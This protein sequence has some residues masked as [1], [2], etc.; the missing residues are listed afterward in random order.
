VWRDLTIVQPLEQPYRAISG[1]GC[2]PVG[3]KIEV[4]RDAVHHGLGNG[5]LVYA[6]G[7]RALGVEDYPDLVVDQIVRIVGEERIHALLCDPRRLRI[8]QRNLL[9]RFACSATAAR[10]ATMST[11]ALP[12]TVAGIEGRKVFS[13]GT[14]CL[15]SLR[16]GNRLVARSPLGLVHIRLDQ[17]RIDR[18][19]LAANKPGSNAY[20]HHALEYSPQSVTLTKALVTRAAEYRMIGNLVLDAELAKPPV[21]QI[22]LNLRAEPPL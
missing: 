17:A 18:K 4:A 20:R 3:P 6:I 22:D 11:I 12:I 21:R 15:L 5:D 10:A 16:P 2:E 8:G 19:R 7:A 13:N 14:G 9:R 1:V